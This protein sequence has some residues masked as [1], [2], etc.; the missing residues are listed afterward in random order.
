MI[1][2]LDFFNWLSKLLKAIWLFIAGV[3]AVLIIY[4]LLIGV[5]QGVDVVIQSGELL[6]SGILSVL[7]VFF[8]SF[9][10]WY[11]SRTLSYI[12]QHKDDEIFSKKTA[13]DVTSAML[14]KKYCIPSN[15]YQHIPRMLAYNCFVSVQVAIFHLPTFF[16][17]SGWIIFCVVV[18]HNIFYFLLV[19][20][21]RSATTSRTRNVLGTIN[22]AIIAGYCTFL[23]YRI[24]EGARGIDLVQHPLRHKCWLS[25]IAL[26][27]FLLQIL[28]VFFFIQRRRS[29][30]ARRKDPALKPSR[31]LAILGFNPAFNAAE[32]PYFHL[33]NGT[34]AVAAT[35][36]LTA[37]FVMP[38]SSL[39][40]PLAFTL[41]A[42][43]VLTGCSNLITLISIRSS[44]NVMIILFAMAFLFGQYRDPYPVR[45]VENENV[46]A[47]ANRPDTKTYL[48]KW[49]EQR[50]PMI[51][52]RD[53]TKNFPV[54]IV[55][56]NG[57]AS[58]AGKWTSSVL[59]HL[60]D[61]SYQS[62]AQDS[63]KDHVLCIAGAS[64][65]SVGNCA[66]YSLL[67][68]SHEG[69]IKPDEFSYHTDSFFETDFLTFTLA[70]LLGPD[71][72]R[73]LLPFNIPLDN[74]A[75]AL[76]KVIGNGSADELLN[77][78]FEKP[79]TEV[80]DTTGA[81]PILFINTTQVDNGMPG[82][83][84]SVLLPE[85]SQRQDV[86]SLVDSMGVHSS[87]GDLRLSTAAVLSSRFP[88]V[89]PAGKVF[90]RYYV[91][92]GYFD[93]SGAG[94]VLEFIQ[95]LNQFM[96]DSTQQS[97]MRYRKRFT[98]HI[99]HITNSE[100]VRRPSKDIHPLT[101][102]L[103]SPVLTLAGMQGSSTSIG[104]GIL[105]N[106]F[107]QFNTDTANAMIVYSLYD[108]T[109]DAAKTTGDY[110][111][112]YPMSWTL[113]DYQLNRMELALQ[114]ANRRNLW[115]FGFGSQ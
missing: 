14:Y 114:R 101:N 16:A 84:S 67:K 59:S 47:F 10:V 112:G 34:A 29:I 35:I 52:A 100:I 106:A 36:Y 53:T 37:I 98:F 89:S 65:G 15:L 69:E 33:L 92:G 108:E 54:Y 46:P 40:G 105:V 55:L 79:V 93:N 57:G 19:K 80:F 6:D 11:S 62:D 74:R 96:T 38:F 56:S 70:R 78:Y 81:L 95:A 71:I 115:K 41:L 28:I 26:S 66:F 31:L 91:D 86:L 4:Y 5:E 75:D 104:D 1:L 12:K 32:T 21:F 87:K 3:I 22:S 88:Y 58:R 50:L 13:G 107:K 103:F 17:W 73:H 77:K 23:I 43:G 99:L 8:W 111:E 42:L 83:I 9:L 63:F 72:F 49:F 45:F 85:N 39:M 76:E 27:M 51:N 68:A 61:T 2:L 82:V 48:A 44:F 102:D 94:T 25:L 20:W 109:W 24:M 60:Q 64:G 30:D 113:S 110:E 7:A 97:I 18:A 90:D